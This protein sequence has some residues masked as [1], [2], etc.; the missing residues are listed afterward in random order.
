MKQ[1]IFPASPKV[2]LRTKRD[3]ET[4]TVTLPVGTYYVK[5]KKKLLQVI[6]SARK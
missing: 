3:G 4:D 5:E 1:K 2:L 6:G